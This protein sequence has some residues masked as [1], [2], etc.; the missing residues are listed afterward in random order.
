MASHTVGTLVVHGP[1]TGGPLSLHGDIRRVAFD[2][3]SGPE[4]PRQ[5]GQTLE[6]VAGLRSRRRGR[7]AAREE[8]LVDGARVLHVGL[9]FTEDVQDD[10]PHGDRAQVLPLVF[11]VN[12][13]AGP[14]TSLL[15]IWVRTPV[16][17][18]AETTGTMKGR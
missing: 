8:E 13:G 14:L 3:D 11:Q 10:R 6:N 15:L 9:A 7:Q 12:D 18:S 17:P 1:H 16:S 2:L 4:W 5:L